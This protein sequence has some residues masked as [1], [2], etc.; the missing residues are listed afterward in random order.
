MDMQNFQFI[1]VLVSLIIG[2]VSVVYFYQSTG[3][4]VNLLKKPLKL[5]SSGMILISFGILLAVFISFYQNQGY[6]IFIKGVPISALFFL[7]YII[8]SIMIFIGAR[9]FSRRPA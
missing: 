2:M 6:A 1:L 9:Q 7:L 4:F 5:I 3:I 8:G